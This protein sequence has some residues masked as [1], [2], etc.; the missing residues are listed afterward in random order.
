M[1][2]TQKLRPKDPLDIHSRLLIDITDQGIEF[3]CFSDDPT[4]QTAAIKKCIVIPWK[5]T[6]L[7]NAIICNHLNEGLNSILTETSMLQLRPFDDEMAL[8]KRKFKPQRSFQLVSENQINHFDEV[9]FCFSSK[10]TKEEKLPSRKI[11]ASERKR[12]LLSRVNHPKALARITESLIRELNTDALEKTDVDADRYTLIEA[13]T[14][15]QLDDSPEE[16][17]SP[18]YGKHF[19]QLTL[20]TTLIKIERLM[21]EALGQFIKKRLKSNGVFFTS[22]RSELSHLL[23]EGDALLVELENKTIF[24]H[25]KIGFQKWPDVSCSENRFLNSL[26]ADM[27]VWRNRMNELDQKLLPKRGEWNPF[28]NKQCDEINSAEVFKTI[29]V[30]ENKNPKKIWDNLSIEHW[31]PLIGKLRQQINPTTTLVLAGNSPFALISLMDAIQREGWNARIAWPTVSVPTTTS[32]PSMRALHRGGEIYQTQENE[33]FPSSS[34][35][36]RRIRKN[37]TKQTRA[38]ALFMLQLAFLFFTRKHTSATAS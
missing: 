7:N 5:Q 34:L 2:S 23:P 9:T 25:E 36:L 20:R 3:I 10:W 27:G 38:A 18:P 12:G 31:A 14:I 32:Q 37:A 8:K 26:C 29:G 1:Q 35:P 19:H 21:A 11:R 30:D 24:I 6:Q 13:R 22:E 17:A 15:Y 4:V 28:L 33:R 16:Y